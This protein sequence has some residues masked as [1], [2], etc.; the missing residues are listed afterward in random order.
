MTA[1]S[2]PR[3]D[4]APSQR[5]LYIFL[6]E[7]G[8]FDFSQSGTRYFTLTCV[9]AQRPFLWDT[10]FPALKYDLLEKGLDIEYFHAAED[11]QMVRDLVFPLIEDCLSSIRIDSLIVEKRKTGPALQPLIKLY[12]EM[13]GYLLRY[14]FQGLGS[15]R[16]EEV[17]VL[18]DRLPVNKKRQ[19][20]EK[21]IKITLS[22]FLPP[23]T[24]YRVLHHESRSCAG[25]QVVD[26]CNWAIYRKW[27][28]G[29]CRSYDLIKRAIRSEFDIFASGRTYYY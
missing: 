6:D 17:V 16:Y 4:A 18:T 11:R 3:K 19:A 14:V 21:A 24:N 2:D 27:A 9:T 22:K 12:P 23:T 29:D 13:L 8:N 7:G 26:Y 20:V 25:L 10:T 5:H 28:K 15:S 1:M